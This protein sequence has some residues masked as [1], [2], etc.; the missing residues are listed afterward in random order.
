MGSL[1]LVQ[2]AWAAEVVKIWLEQT[3]YKKVFLSQP[4]YII[5]KM[6]KQSNKNELLKIIGTYVNHPMRIR[7][8]CRGAWPP[9][10]CTCTI[11]V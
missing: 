6:H 7:L 8:P 2:V 1:F 5:K 4:T 10:V 9:A 11:V 3:V